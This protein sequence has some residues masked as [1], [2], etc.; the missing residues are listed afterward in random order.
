MAIVNTCAMQV[1]TQA[2]DFAA[3]SIPF[4]T[5]SLVT[6]LPAAETNASMDRS[7]QFAP[8]SSA[9]AAS[10][11]ARPEYNQL[12]PI[13]SVDLSAV[14]SS[15]TVPSGGAGGQVQELASCSIDIDQV[16]CRLVLRKDG[17]RLISSGAPQTTPTYARG[18]CLIQAAGEPKRYRYDLL[19]AEDGSLTAPAD[20]TR[21]VGRA[22]TVGLQL[23]ADAQGDQMSRR[24]QWSVFVPPDEAMLAEAAIARQ[25]T[26]PVSGRRLG[27]MGQP[28]AVPLASRTIYVCTPA[29]RDK[30]LHDKGIFSLDSSSFIVSSATA[31]D[32]PAID[33]QGVCPVMDEPLGGMGPPIKVLMGDQAVF[34]CCRGCIKK[35]KADPV[36]YLAKLHAQGGGNTGNIR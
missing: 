14:E 2:Q 26:C 7:S 35:L 4:G 9:P 16:T 3:H 24:L 20:L 29:C 17:I 6:E 12:R 5:E 21:L 27:S 18:I 11:Q 31:D 36:K 13:P 34:L 15:Q 30:L 22:V 1:S 33:R 32:Q 10:Q 25:A 8:L 19:P 28:I 23:V